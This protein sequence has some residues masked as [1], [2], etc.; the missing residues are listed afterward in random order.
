MTYDI[1]SWRRAACRSPDPRL[2][3]YITLTRTR[4]GEPSLMPFTPRGRGEY[5][6]LVQVSGDLRNQHL[7]L[8][9]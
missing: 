5:E 3:H 4:M 2:D 9:G 7:G 8:A 1:G 6:K